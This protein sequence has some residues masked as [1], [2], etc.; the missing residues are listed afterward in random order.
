MH[1]YP[2]LKLCLVPSGDGILLIQHNDLMNMLI[3]SILVLN[4]LYYRLS[5]S[6]SVIPASSLWDI[7]ILYCLPASE[8]LSNPFAC[9]KKTASFGGRFRFCSWVRSGL[10][11]H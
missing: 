5:S 7:R 1:C 2:Y 9:P 10:D 4:D 8:S 11:Q 6:A 3:S